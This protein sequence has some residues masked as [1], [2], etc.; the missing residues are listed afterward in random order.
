MRNNLKAIVAGTAFFSF[1]CVF[2]HITTFYGLFIPNVSEINVIVLFLMGYGIWHLIEIVIIMA[3]IGSGCL[4]FISKSDVILKL[5]TISLMSC[6]LI[7]FSAGIQ[8]LTII[9]NVLT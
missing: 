6:G 9:L 5:S 7:R 4:A 3:G 2:D 8:N 1:S